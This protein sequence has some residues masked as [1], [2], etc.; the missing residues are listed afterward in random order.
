MNKQ[1]THKKR[2][3][4]WLALCL[5][6]SI[7]GALA[8]IQDEG[9]EDTTI[10]LDKATARKIL[11]E[12]KKSNELIQDLVPDYAN[13]WLTTDRPHVAETP[14]LVPK[15]YLQY[16]TGFQMQKS[17]TEIEKSKEITYNTTLVRIGL[18]R[19]VEA[20]IQTDFLGTTTY[21]RSNDSLVRKIS[22]FTGLSLG[23]KVFL[24]NARGIRPRGT[25][26][27]FVSFPFWGSKDYRASYLT[28][29]DIKF[30]FLNRITNHYEFEYNVGF[31]WNGNTQNAAYSYALNNE[32]EVNHQFFFFLELYGYFYENSGEDNRFDGT[33]TN[34]HR[35]N[36][37]IWYR[38][39]PG[40]QLD[41]SGGFG[42]S[43]VSPTYYVSVGLSNR[44]SLGKRSRH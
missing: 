38:L 18:S 23:S 1:T 39:S 35:V 26:L 22:G 5:L 28:A 36:G 7:T 12:Y 21:N 15:G 33:F 10:V 30:L 17:R 19:R 27:Y 4:K 34:D 9:R 41:L 24:F 3:I 16:E 20:R 40:L 43:K 42:L 44:L 11:E 31:Q 32:F 8:Q 25:L 6:F 37:G 13:E 29:T 14:I 2:R